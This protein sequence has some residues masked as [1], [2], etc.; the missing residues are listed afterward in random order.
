VCDVDEKLL[1]DARRAQERLQHAEQ[2]TEAARAEFH[3]AVHRLVSHGALPRDAAAALGLSDQ[4]VHQIAQRAGGHGREGRDTPP[5]N[6]LACTFCGNSQYQVRKL[7]AGPSVYICDACVELARG[8][9]SSGSAASTRLGPVHAVADQDGRVRCRFCGKHR[10]E[11]AGMAAM[12]AGPGDEA[13]GPAAI[14]AECLSLCIEIITE[15][16]T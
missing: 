3:R 5:D 6:G 2:E 1:A 10:D 15:E 7:I 13:S 14:C 9:I 8:M 12:P 4:Q 11:V 16:L